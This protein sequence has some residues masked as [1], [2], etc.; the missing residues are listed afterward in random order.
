[1]FRT[2]RRLS[3]VVYSFPNPPILSPDLHPL[4]AHVG[5]GSKHQPKIL[6]PPA[7]PISSRAEEAS[8][9]PYIKSLHPLYRKQLLMEP[10]LLEAMGMK[11]R[12]TLLH[13]LVGCEAKLLPGTVGP[14]GSVESMDMADMVI[15]QYRT[16]SFYDRVSA[17][18][19][20]SPSSLILPLYDQ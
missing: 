3:E 19:L 9:S 14:N 1:M 6:S 18:A 15:C 16:G 2:G 13:L 11:T 8:A 5:L 4:Q 12:R 20:P 17:H 10:S 7:F